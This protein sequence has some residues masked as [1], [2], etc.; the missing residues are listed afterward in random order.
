MHS[1][2]LCWIIVWC[3]GTVCLA[4]V[5]SQVDNGKHLGTSGILGFSGKEIMELM[6]CFCE[7]YT[8]SNYDWSFSH[9]RRSLYQMVHQRLF[10]QS[11]QLWVGWWWYHLCDCSDGKFPVGGGVILQEL[12]LNKGIIV[13]A[14]WIAF[15]Q[16]VICWCLPIAS[17]V[18]SSMRDMQDMSKDN[19]RASNLL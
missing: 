12:L 9:T 10:F 1:K 13:N 19:S 16:S 18:F 5:I 15:Q 6:W 8:L 3:P 7:H 11:H 2:H 4:S 14:L 17:N